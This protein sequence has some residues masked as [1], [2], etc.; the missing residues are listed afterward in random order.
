[1]PV[2]CI[3]RG[4]VLCGLLGLA[5]PAARADQICRPAALPPLNPC[6]DDDRISL[7]AVG[8]V[9][10]H[11]ALQRRA[12]AQG[13][14]SLWQAAAPWFLGADIAIANLETP[15]APCFVRGGRQVGDPGLVFD[16]RV[17]QGY[18]LFNAHP[19]AI[20]ALRAAGVSVVTTANNHALDR[21][22]AGLDATLEELARRGMHQ[23]G[24]I[25]RGAPRDFVLR[26]RSRMG[27]LSLIGCSYSTNGIPDP[28][29]QVLMCHEDRDE[30]LGLVGHEASRPRSA[31]VI[32]LPHWGIEYSH[33]PARRDRDLARDLVA[34]GAIAVIGTHPHVVQ[35]WEVI[36]G[37]AGD[38]LV[39][40]ST[41]N[42][43]SAQRSLPRATGQMVVAELC[44]GP[45]G[46]VL[47]GAGW[48]PV[49]MVA[50]R[51]GLTLMLPEPGARGVPGQARALV[52]RLVP[53]RD[54][55]LAAACQPFDPAAAGGQRASHRADP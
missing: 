3:L 44:R 7:V 8:D 20:D 49:L 27:V 52:E 1:M 42:F 51:H 5:A 46:V 2:S 23:T 50:D 28:Q 16:D 34:A 14:L 40:Y 30:L 45:A 19:A 47:A 6:L 9:L 26:I 48:V 21:G 36:P 18:P 33:S 13:Y 38:A 11:R 29:R 12:A 15:T 25:R 10:L 32:V 41:G 17:Y 37:A 31:G 54:V 55:S 24:T 43:V 35:P 39:A 22:P 4:L 53:G